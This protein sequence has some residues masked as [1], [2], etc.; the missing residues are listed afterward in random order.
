MLNRS[1]GKCLEGKGWGAK[2]E[3]VMLRCPAWSPGKGSWIWGCGQ[4]SV[5]QVEPEDKKGG[6]PGTRT[7]P[8]GSA[9]DGQGKKDSRGD[10]HDG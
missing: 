7:T 8:K 9:I 3:C 5:I 6:S 1:C 10:W 4:C 2:E